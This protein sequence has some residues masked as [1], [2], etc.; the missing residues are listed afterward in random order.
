MIP[1][2]PMLK[3]INRVKACSVNPI[4][5]KVR[6]GVYDDA[7]GTKIPQPSTIHRPSDQPLTQTR[8][9]QE[10]SPRLPHHRLRRLRYCRRSRAGLR[11]LQARR[12]RLIR[13]ISDSPRQQCRVP[14]RQRVQLR[15]QTQVV[16]FCR[17]GELWVD[18]RD[19]LAVAA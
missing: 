11:I 10:R 1:F 7:P 2:S 14:A 6:G 15:S 3:M 5:C 17:G 9:L 4:D 19:G 12:R 18:V 8:L 13:R 16:G